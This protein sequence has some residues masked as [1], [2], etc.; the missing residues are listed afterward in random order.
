MAGRATYLRFLGNVNTLLTMAT[1]HLTRAL[2][3]AL[4]QSPAS[5]RGLAEAAGIDHTM[6]AHVLAG[7]RR[8]SPA[9]VRRVAKALARWGNNCASGAAI[10]RGALK[11]D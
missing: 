3:L 11:E 9:L 5:R 4:A 6:L 2:R 10:L 8:A 1:A 7:R